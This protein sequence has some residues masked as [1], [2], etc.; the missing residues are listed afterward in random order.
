M[1][2]LTATTQ[3]PKEDEKTEK[4]KA[5]SVQKPVEL[6]P[7]AVG[8][9]TAPETKETTSS[10]EATPSV[11]PVNQKPMEVTPPMAVGLIALP[12]TPTVQDPSATEDV[13]HTSS[14]D[15][16][17]IQGTVYR[18][19]EQGG[20]LVRDARTRQEFLLVFDEAMPRP[21]WLNDGVE[22]EVLGQPRPNM[23]TV[24]MLGTPLVVDDIQL[25]RTPTQPR[26]DY[27]TDA[28]LSVISRASGRTAANPSVT[29][30]QL[31]RFLR[32]A[33]RGS[34]D[35]QIAAML[36]ENFDT[37]MS[38]YRYGYLAE[39]GVVQVNVNGQQSESSYQ[40]R[41][42]YGETY[43]NGALDARTI[44]RVASLDGNGK[45]F[46]ANDLGRLRKMQA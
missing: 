12:T 17:R 10:K 40:E 2:Q 4:A 23:P 14:Q 27:D 39:Q 13:H 33:M 30:E 42:Y 32:N 43:Y 37:L 41:Y 35:A 5:D 26:G 34:P 36:L 24:Y 29:R 45:T 31:Q 18:S 21:S 16:Q 11:T 15:R 7:M 38:P 8:L 9:R 20:W 6:P 3:D 44:Q 25:I 46:S 1:V 22:V 28:V 19:V